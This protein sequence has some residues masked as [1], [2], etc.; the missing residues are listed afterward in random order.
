MIHTA[1]VDSDL[2][3]FFVAV[4]FFFSEARGTLSSPRRR[5]PGTLEQGI[6]LDYVSFHR[7]RNLKT[8][9]C[10]SII[11]FFPWLFT[12]RSLASGSS[13]VNS[14]THKKWLIFA[15]CFGLEKWKQFPCPGVISEFFV[16]AS[17]SGELWMR[18]NVPEN[19]V[20]DDRNWTE[21]QKDRQSSVCFI[22]NYHDKLVISLT[23]T[24]S[25][26]LFLKKNY[27]DLE[28]GM[29]FQFRW[30]HC[31]DSDKSQWEKEMHLA[32]H[33]T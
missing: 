26:P 11:Y 21:R 9:C 14:G 29:F 24:S 22:C 13:A 1:A 20:S 10:S 17:F 28:D 7:I 3:G 27:P 23:S 25:F 16:T 18:A 5:S 15:F 2:P 33:K 31:T 19:S 32:K 30:I 12:Q 4:F 8:E 6:C